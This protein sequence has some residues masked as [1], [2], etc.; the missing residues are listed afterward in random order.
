MPNRPTIPTN[1]NAKQKQP[2][3]DTHPTQLGEAPRP[4]CFAQPPEENAPIVS[5][6][7]KCKNRAAHVWEPD[8][9]KL[10][11]QKKPALN[12]QN[13]AQGLTYNDGL[14]RCNDI[15]ATDTHAHGKKR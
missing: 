14:P 6:K 4:S 13:A 7:Q 8:A 15:A 12:K 5:K 3:S 10:P 2:T 1:T 11:N 9:F